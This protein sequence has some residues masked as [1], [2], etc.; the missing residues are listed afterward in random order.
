MR[1]SADSYCAHVVLRFT[2]SVFGMVCRPCSTKCISCSHRTCVIG[3]N[4][5]SL[6]VLD[7]LFRNMLKNWA[8]IWPC[9]CTCFEKVKA[10]L[11]SKGLSLLGTY[12]L[13]AI[14]HICFVRDEYLLYIRQR[15]HLYL[16]KPVLDIIE[17]VFLGAVIDE[18]DAHRA[19][20]I[21]LRNGSESFLAS[22]VPHL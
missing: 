19:F 7:D 15:M 16:I 14:R 1:V 4:S 17:G 2:W 6:K 8:Y 18:Q 9:L 21:G 5:L 13:V 12:F 20:I 3:F 11:I 10:V 22:S